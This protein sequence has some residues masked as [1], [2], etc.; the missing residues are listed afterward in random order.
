M[1]LFLSSTLDGTIDLFMREYEMDPKNTPVV[2]IPTAE[3]CFTPPRKISERGSYRCLVDRDFPITICDLDK[4]SLD[5]MKVKMERAK[6]IV[7]G[8]GNT[9]YLLYHMKLIGFDKLLPT[10]LNQGVIYVGSSAGSC[11]CSP[12][13]EYVKDEDDPAFAPDLK[14]YTGLNL[15][16]FEIYPH[17]TEATPSTS[18][19]IYLRDNQAIVASD[20]EYKIVSA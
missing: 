6:V 8:G 5:D 20:D 4:D 16:R 19:K 2:Y 9:F 14:D 18:K 12:N 3:N 10:L 15:V 7:C 17:R 1:H 11:V 13:I